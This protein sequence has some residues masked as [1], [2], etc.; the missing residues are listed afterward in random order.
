MA[1]IIL[2]IKPE[3]AE[4]ILN[5]EKL[6]EF[7]KQVPKKKIS[8]V[9]IYASSPYKKIIGRF[10]VNNILNGT[11]EEIWNLCGSQGGI[12]QER[13]FEYCGNNETIYGFE[14]SDVIKFE[15]PI[16]PY[17]EDSN[18][19]APQSFAYFDNHLPQI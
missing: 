15:T 9:F 3:F 7:R 16:N 12:D 2:S 17:E 4:K 5:G 13:F 1:D 8:W 6:F 18:F 19:N 14:I 10:R 11:P